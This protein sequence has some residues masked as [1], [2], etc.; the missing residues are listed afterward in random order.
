[1]A[2]LGFMGI[3]FPEKHGGAG[4]DY[5]SYVIVIEEI[6]AACASTGVIVSA[7]TSL[8][9]DPIYF[10]GTE[11][12]K[13]KF[14]VP[15]A[16]GEKIGCLGLTESSAG[17]D[18]SNIKTTAQLDGNHWIINGSKL[19]ITNAAQADIAVITAFTDKSQGNRGISTFIVEKGTSGFKVGKIEE[20]LGIKASSTA[21]LIFEDCRIPKEN[22]LGA[23]G[24]GFKIALQTLD[25][26]RIGIAAQA[27]GIARGALEASIKYSKERIQFNQS[28]SNFQAI[29]WMISDMATGIDAARL[30]ALRAA[31]LKV[32]NERYTTQAAMAKLFA[33]E[34]ATDVTHKAIQIYGGYGYTRDYPVERFYR[35]ARIT[36]IYEGTSEIQRLVIAASLLK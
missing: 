25:G 6:S 35:D 31:Y 13:Q 14:L 9:C 21:E 18:A 24:G 7:H 2:E 36:E 5:I 29:Q 8:C 4:L 15:L 20:K 1:L 19:F 34:M 32:N 12:Q 3:P 26:G 17:S 33:S 22:L 27:V 23:P 11:E 30:L 16:R 10:A 28:I